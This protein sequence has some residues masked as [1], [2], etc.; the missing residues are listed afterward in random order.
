MAT[1]LTITKGKPRPMIRSGTRGTKGSKV[2]KRLP[3][4]RDVRLAIKSAKVK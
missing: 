1:R 4:W 2:E 3:R